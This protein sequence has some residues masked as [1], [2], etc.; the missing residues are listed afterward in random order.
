MSEA[1]IL[2]RPYAIILFT[3]TTSPFYCEVKPEDVLRNR[4]MVASFRNVCQLQSFVYQGARKL[5]PLRARSRHV[6]VSEITSLH[7][8]NYVGP[9][10]ENGVTVCFVCSRTFTDFCT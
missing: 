9:E 5:T 2:L 1:A 4:V 7:L 10:V 6:S 3:Y 8:D